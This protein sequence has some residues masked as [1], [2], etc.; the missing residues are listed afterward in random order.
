M[1]VLGVSLRARALP[2]PGVGC[3]VV[4]RLFPDL[5]ALPEREADSAPFERGARACAQQC[6]H[7][8]GEHDRR[9]RA[10]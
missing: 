10:Q 3:V 5:V 9:Q 1:G 6:A 8:L 2:R 7:G 4:L